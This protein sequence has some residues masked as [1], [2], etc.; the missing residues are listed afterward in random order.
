MDG[1]ERRKRDEITQK[2]AN[3]AN[4]L[5]EVEG[6]KE[7]GLPFSR[8]H[9]LTP[10]VAP[11]EPPVRL[12]L[13]S[14]HDHSPYTDPLGLRSRKV[15]QRQ[16][17]AVGRGRRTEKQQIAVGRGRR[18]EGRPVRKAKRGAVAEVGGSER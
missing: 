4:A 2:S 11:M 15:Q 12:T 17:T 5:V 9:L 10:P 16:Q 7:W 13:R 18:K 1:K 14:S 3:A 6:C 8:I